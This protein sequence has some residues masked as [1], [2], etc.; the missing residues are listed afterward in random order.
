MDIIDR[1]IVDYSICRNWG[2]IPSA[3]T[4]GTYLRHLLPNPALGDYHWV[5]GKP[6]GAQAW[7]VLLGLDC[8]SPLLQP[9]IVDWNCQTIGHSLGYSI[10][11]SAHRPVWL[12]ISD[13]SLERGD[14]W[15]ALM[16]WH[17][18]KRHCLFVTV[19]CNGYGCKHP[20]EKIEDLYNKILSFN[21]ACCIAQPDDVCIQDGI[22]LVDTS[23]SLGS[24]MKRLGM[25]YTKFKSFEDFYAQCCG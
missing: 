3:L 20:C 22:V 13:A 21:V 5:A 8:D 6:F 2:H 24:K 23:S 11:V 4:Q 25:H 9:P 12:N 10:G 14:F 19:D 1:K 18:F 15:E 17:E 16:L 7:Y